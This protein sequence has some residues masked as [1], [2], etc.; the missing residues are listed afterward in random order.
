MLCLFFGPGEFVWSFPSRVANCFFVNPVLSKYHDSYTA[1]GH[2]DGVIAEG[3]YTCNASGKITAEW[4]NVLKL[5]GTEW[6]VSNVA[7][8]SSSLV[9]E[10]N[11]DDGKILC[12]SDNC[13]VCSFALILLLSFCW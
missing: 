1:F 2:A 3:K 13:T 7:A 9:T 4:D 5:E 10:F 12:D 6:K 11:L 8:E